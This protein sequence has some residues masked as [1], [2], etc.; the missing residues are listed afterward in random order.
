MMIE[1]LIQCKEVSMKVLSPPTGVTAINR[2]RSV[3][4]LPSLSRFSASSIPDTK[5]RVV[6]LTT[7]VLV[8]LSG[9]KTQDKRQK[10]KKRVKQPGS[11]YEKSKSINPT[12][13]I[14]SSL[15]TVLIN[16]RASIWF[17]GIPWDIYQFKYR[18]LLIA[19]FEQRQNLT[20]S[21]RGKAIRSISGSL[22][23]LRWEDIQEL[24]PLKFQVVQRREMK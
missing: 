2:S 19:S 4:R 24:L 11:G 6:S 9:G 14:F 1:R 8:R 23:S 17:F 16:E 5:A 20:L 3:M 21:E 12:P 18:L 22:T 15:V 13:A 10:K 7:V